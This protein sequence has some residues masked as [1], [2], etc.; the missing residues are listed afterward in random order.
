VKRGFSLL[1]LLRS[2]GGDTPALLA[3]I[4]PSAQKG[5]SP[6]FG[7]KRRGDLVWGFG[8]LIRCSCPR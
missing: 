4:H 6:K 2:Q 3:L 7:A 8:P 1:V 5:C